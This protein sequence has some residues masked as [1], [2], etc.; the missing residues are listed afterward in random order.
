MVADFG[1]EIS[2]NNAQNGIR[3]FLHYSLVLIL[4]DE[5]ENGFHTDSY[6]SLSHSYFNE[7]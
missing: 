4:C 1:G 7:F 5:S 6:T 3:F 2:M